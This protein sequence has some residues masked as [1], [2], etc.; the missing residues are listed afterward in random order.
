MD[1]NCYHPQVARS[2]LLAKS[3]QQSTIYPSHLM[4][5]ISLLL[6]RFAQGKIDPCQEN[7]TECCTKESLQSSVRCILYMVLLRE[8]MFCVRNIQCPAAL[9]R[10]PWFF[11]HL[12]N[13][14]LQTVNKTVKK[15]VKVCRYR[16]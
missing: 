10:T 4:S 1:S 3:H 15:F 12:H 16:V 2:L 8:G 7:P 11:R 13:E 14:S 5:I 9:Y 6:F